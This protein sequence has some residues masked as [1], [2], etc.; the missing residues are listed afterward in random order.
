MN[1]M[2]ANSG[3]PVGPDVGC[4]CQTK[5]N[6][7]PPPI[8]C[9]DEGQNCTCKGTV[10]FGKQSTNETGLY[11]AFEDFVTEPYAY[12]QNTN[13]NTSCMADQ[14]SGEYDFGQNSLTAS[15][16]CFCDSVGY[17]G[18]EDIDRDV[19][20]FAAEYRQYQL[21]QQ[22]AAIEAERD[23]LRDAATAAAANAANAA[24]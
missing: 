21:E 22:Q 14:F 18:A 15:S 16:S 24:V 4:L 23:Q 7:F 1:A 6:M 2:R 17:Y 5:P 3:L 13:G 8:K 11:T 20:Y 12:K 10:F 19:T 9:A